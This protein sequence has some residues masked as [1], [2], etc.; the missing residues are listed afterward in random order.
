MLRIFSIIVFLLL[1]SLSTVFAQEEKTDSHLAGEYFRNNEYEKAAVI[2]KKLYEKRHSHIY[3]NYYL[4][5]LLQMEDFREARKLVKVRMDHNPSRERYLVDLGYVFITEGKTSKGKRYYEQAINEL[6]VSRSE[7]SELANAFLYRRED[8][9]AIKA[10]LKGRKLL[11]GKYEFHYQLARIFKRLGDYDKMVDE[12]LDL[13]EFDRSKIHIVQSRLQ[14]ALNDD[15]QGNI[16]VALRNELLRRIQNYPEKGYYSEMMLWLAVQEKDFESAFIQAK[17]IDRRAMTDGRNVFNIAGMAASNKAY[18]IAHDAYNYVINNTADRYMRIKSKVELLNVEFQ[19]ATLGEVPDKERLAELE[20]QYNNTIAE[21]GRNRL[22]IPLMRNLAHIQAFYLYKVDPAVSVLEEAIQFSG[23]QKKGQALCKMELAD[24]LLFSGRPW[25]ATLLYSQVEKSFKND[26]LGHEAKF[27]NAKLSF[28]I[29]EFDWAKA[30]LD[31]LKAAT[32]K[33]IANDAM[34]LSLLISDNT[35]Q[36]SVSEGLQMYARA[37]L[38]LFRNNHEKALQTLDS[39]NKLPNALSHALADEVLFK[40]SQIHIQQQNFEL[41]ASELQAIIDEHAQ[42]IL[43]DNALFELAGLYKNHLN[44]KD[45]AM[46]LYQKLI[47]EYAGSIYVVNARKHFRELRGDQ[48][49]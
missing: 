46:Q 30:Q 15:L 40:K 7:V 13:I 2:Y 48:V 26:P 10:Y 39:I 12:Y 27:R 20:T 1:A 35:D 36:D 45:K 17:A 3:Y 37:D 11:K 33:L 32:S 28:Y 22:T 4:H 5:C 24:I 21:L 16:N 38:H 29:G 18:R 34:E 42:E 23:N 49:N 43:A 44:D 14:T 31:V 9:F 19:Q 47:T 8:E 41:A 25:D 6:S